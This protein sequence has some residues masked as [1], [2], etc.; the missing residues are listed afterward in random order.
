MKTIIAILILGL[1]VLGYIFI[2]NNQTSS[3]GETNY[4]SNSNPAENILESEEAVE[5]SFGE[6]DPEKFYPDAPRN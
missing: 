3:T 5:S 2:K 1:I 6:R 4:P